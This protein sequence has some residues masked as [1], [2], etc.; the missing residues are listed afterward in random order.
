MQIATFT[1]L[2]LP[3]VLPAAPWPAADEEGLP[4]EQA[5]CRHPQMA[6]GLGG[7]WGS[8]ALH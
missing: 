1:C 3:A 4:D 6:K 7:L 5:C 2:P 8:P